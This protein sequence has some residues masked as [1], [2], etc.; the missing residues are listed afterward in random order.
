MYSG[1]TIALQKAITDKDVLLLESNGRLNKETLLRIQFEDKISLFD[2]KQCM[3]LEIS[4]E[5]SKRLLELEAEV[6]RLTIVQVE[7]EQMLASL[8]SDLEARQRRFVADMTAAHAETA[9]LKSRLESQIK[10]MVDIEQVIRP[11]VKHNLTSS[12]YL[13]VYI[14][15]LHLYIGGR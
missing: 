5:K 3:E 2:K 12:R 8:S 13:L 4:R 9:L 1:Q 11:H 6:S 15:S 7:Q 14:T 10:S